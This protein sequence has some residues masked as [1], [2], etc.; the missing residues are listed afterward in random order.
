MI[1]VIPLERRGQNQR[2][3]VFDA[4]LTVER[5]PIKLTRL[6]SF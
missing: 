5:N 4:E 6:T 3:A 2:A 1:A